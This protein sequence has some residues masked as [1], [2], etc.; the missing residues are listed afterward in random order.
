MYDFN[1]LFY[2]TA[3]S[4][5]PYQMLGLAIQ[6]A[7]LLDDKLLLVL[8]VFG[9]L[10]EKYFSRNTV[11]WMVIQGLCWSYRAVSGPC[12]E[13]FCWAVGMKRK[14]GA[15]ARFSRYIHIYLFAR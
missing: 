7:S 6:P 14:H 4:A 13:P 12:A 1:T 3:L 11:Y 10:E 8:D 5:K 9:N 2:A 15:S